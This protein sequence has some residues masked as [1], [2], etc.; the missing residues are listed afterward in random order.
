[1]FDQTP[2]LFQNRLDLF[3]YYDQG[4]VSPLEVG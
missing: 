2:T 1:M 3:N 4:D